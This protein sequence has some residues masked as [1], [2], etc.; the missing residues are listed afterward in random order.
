VHWLHLNALKDKE[1]TSA[2]GSLHAT[3]IANA[4][5]NSQANYIHIFSQNY[6]K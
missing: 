2:V 1:L 3:A 4:E 5:S 6:N